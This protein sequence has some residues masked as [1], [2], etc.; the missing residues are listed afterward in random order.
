LQVQTKLRRGVVQ[1]ALTSDLVFDVVALHSEV[2]TLEA[3]D[4][5]YF[6]RYNVWG[7]ACAQAA[8]LG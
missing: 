1:I 3:G 7:G 6:H 2:F 5:I 8:A 4:T